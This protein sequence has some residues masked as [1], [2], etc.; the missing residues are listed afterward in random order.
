[1]G[2][3]IGRGLD[4]G[5]TWGSGRLP[6]GGVGTEA[7]E[8]L[9]RNYEINTADAGESPDHEHLIIE[10]LVA[11]LIRDKVKFNRTDMVFITRDKTGQVI[12][13]EKGNNLAGLTHLNE[14]G[15]IKDLSDKFG[16]AEKDVPKLIRNIVRDGTVISSRL[17][18]RHGR[19]GYERRYE[20]QGKQVVLAAIGTNGFLVSIYP[21]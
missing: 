1:M 14:R 7:L 2:G 13:L 21:I 10:S 20:Y 11:E 16:V 12:W 6:L 15:H 8:E 18:K 5:A 19:D 9:V 4:F 3:G 17:V